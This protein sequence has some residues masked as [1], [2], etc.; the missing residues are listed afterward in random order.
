MLI[1]NYDYDDNMILTMLTSNEV[2][3][4]SFL[5]NLISHFRMKIV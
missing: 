3:P 5:I 1:S 2:D 4:T